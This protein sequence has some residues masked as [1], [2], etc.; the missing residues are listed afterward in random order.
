MV[1]PD[2]T[3]SFISLLTSYSNAES[4]YEI[5]L[6]R[7]DLQKSQID[8]T[9]II[10]PMS[11]VITDV[12]SEINEVVKSG[13]TIIVMSNENNNDIEAV[14]GLPEKYINDV[15]NGDEAIVSIRSIDQSFKG[16]VTEIGYTSSATGVTYPVTISLESAGNKKLRPDMPADVTFQFGSAKEKP[17]LIA[18]LK[19]IASGVDGNY[20]FM[21]SPEDEYHIAR[22]AIVEL[23]QITSNGYEIKAGLKEGDI[24]AV[25]GLSSLYEGRKVKLLEQ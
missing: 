17:M 10:A 20:V 11:G 1:L 2:F 21:L 5:A 23:G 9:E 13:S 24:V 15:Q 3:T 8:Y 6:K 19:S 18:P 7:L 25:A 14:V 16:L 4:S 22:K 12:K